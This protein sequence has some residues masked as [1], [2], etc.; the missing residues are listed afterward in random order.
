MQAFAGPHQAV[1]SSPLFESQALAATLHSF[2][3]SAKSGEALMPAPVEA[4]SFS[5]IE[6]ARHNFQ[7]RNLPTLPRS[8]HQLPRLTAPRRP[9][10]K[11]RER[12]AA[13]S[14]QLLLGPGGPDV[15]AQHT[16]Q[17]LRALNIDAPPGGLSAATRDHPFLREFAQDFPQGVA[18]PGMHGADWANEF[19]EASLHFLGRS[20]PA[21]DH[22]SSQEV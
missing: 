12:S 5:E 18:A 20:S 1:P 22:H 17:L 4:L 10:M 6:K 11:I 9:Q 15:A 7:Q 21:S 2:I 19:A 16:M 8:Q 13:L 3:A 14:R